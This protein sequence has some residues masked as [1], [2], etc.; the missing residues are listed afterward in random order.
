MKKIIAILISFLFVASTLSFA[1]ANGGYDCCDPEKFYVSKT[2]VK[3]GETFAVYYYQSFVSGCYAYEVNPKDELIE[4]ILINVY[5]DGKLFV[6][7]DLRK[8]ETLPGY[9][10][11]CYIEEVY[12]AVKPGKVDF[13]R[14]K[15][16]KETVTISSRALPMDKF[17]KFFGLGKFKD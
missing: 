13:I 3:V 11:E 1:S 6:S 15:T 12:K 16:C 9:I 8:G 17:M 2:S 5:K 7:Y 14:T 4:K 10:D